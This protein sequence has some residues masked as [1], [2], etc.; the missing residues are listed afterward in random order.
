[1]H[2]IPCPTPDFHTEIIGCYLTC[3][4]S[5]FWET[6]AHFTNDF[7]LKIEFCWQIGLLYIDSLLVTLNLYTCHDSTS[8]MSSAKIYSDHFIIIQITA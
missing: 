5:Y 8:V 2:V 3:C 1:M 7:A 6:W 4:N